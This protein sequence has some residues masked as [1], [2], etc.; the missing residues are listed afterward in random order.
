MFA[1]EKDEKE[2]D[3]NLQ[4]YFEQNQYISLTTQNKSE[5]YLEGQIEVESSK[6]PETPIFCQE[7]EEQGPRGI[8]TN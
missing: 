7:K 8:T 2:S 1:E 4:K 5:L 6:L 3:Q